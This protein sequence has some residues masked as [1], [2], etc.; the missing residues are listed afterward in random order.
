MP[1]SAPT[2]ATALTQTDSTFSAGVM[3]VL[4]NMANRVASTAMKYDET[5]QLQSRAEIDAYVRKYHEHYAEMAHSFAMAVSYL[6]SPDVRLWPDNGRDDC[7]SLSGSL[8]GMQFG[9]IWRENADGTGRWS[10]H[11]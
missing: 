5:A 3:H 8:H 9:I 1:T 6:A 2:P 11:S 7:L 4:R 10:F